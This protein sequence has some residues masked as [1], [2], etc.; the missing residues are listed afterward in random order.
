LLRAVAQEPQPR[1][2]REEA[3]PVGAQA[4][5]EDQRPLVGPARGRPGAAARPEGQQQA[6]GQQGQTLAQD[7][8]PHLFAVE[9]DAHVFVIQQM[10][11]EWQGLSSGILRA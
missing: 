3:A 1:L 10:T 8:A 11:I 7:R 6:M 2:E 5:Q 9:V 4:V